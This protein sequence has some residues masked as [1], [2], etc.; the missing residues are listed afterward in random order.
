[1]LASVTIMLEN[2]TKIGNRSSLPFLPSKR[3]KTIHGTIRCIS[4]RIGRMYWFQTP[5]S[6]GN[7]CIFLTKIVY[8]TRSGSV[9]TGPN[10]HFVNHGEGST[11]HDNH[12]STFKIRN[13]DTINFFGKTSVWKIKST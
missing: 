5:H 6:G 8:R 9:Q 1:M 7:K 4:P 13:C 11:F 10:R 12:L 3:N 2:H